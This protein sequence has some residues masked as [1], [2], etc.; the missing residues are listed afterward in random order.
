MVCSQALSFK[1]KGSHPSNLQKLPILKE[2]PK[3][4]LSFQNLSELKFIGCKQLKFILSSS[5]KKSIPELRNLYI[6]EC[7]ELL[8]IIED[9]EENQ[10]NP[11][12][13]HQ[14]CFPKLYRIQVEQC[15]KLKYL[16][17]ITT[18]PK[19]P[20]LLILSVENAPELEQVFGWKQGAPLELIIMD[21]FPN[22]IGM[23]LVNLPNLHTI[24]QGIDFQTVKARIVR[25]CNNI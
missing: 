6:S 19:L 7:E 23:R 11:Y 5:T 25:D 24:F 14:S 17:S 1:E 8:N 15:K 3:N 18:C 13:L 22:L 20:G 12:D 9:D 21:V 16:F 4:L 10:K 2:R